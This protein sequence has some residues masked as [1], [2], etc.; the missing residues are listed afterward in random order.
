MRPPYFTP[1]RVLLSPLPPGLTVLRPCQ[2]VMMLSMY[3]KLRAASTVSKSSAPSLA[4]ASATS[5]SCSPACARTSTGPVLYWMSRDQRAR[6]NHA[7]NYALRLARSRTVPVCVAFALCTS[8]G[9]A[10]ARHFRF[11]LDG[12]REVELRF[13]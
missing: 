11:M 2:V 9:H 10:T 13:E 6:D 4:R 1:T 3:L 5:L 8:F 7:L 12:L